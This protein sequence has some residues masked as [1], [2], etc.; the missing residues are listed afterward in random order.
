MTPNVG[1]ADRIARIIIGLV[2]LSLPFWVQG[3]WRWVGLL[4][5]VPIITALMSWCPIYKIVGVGTS[6][7]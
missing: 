1:T 6:K 7:P 2:L 3:D 5:I 4:G